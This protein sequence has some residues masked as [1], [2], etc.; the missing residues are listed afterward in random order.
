MYSNQLPVV[1][2][3]RVPPHVSIMQAT[4][5]SAKNFPRLGRNQ[6]TKNKFN[7]WIE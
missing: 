3:T 6:E 2:L 4:I 1:Y 7:F 5:V